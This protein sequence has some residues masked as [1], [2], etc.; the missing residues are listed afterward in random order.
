MS[1]QKYTSELNPLDKKVVKEF[2][3]NEMDAYSTVI[4]DDLLQ[5]KILNYKNKYM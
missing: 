4:V 2:K 3:E 1:Y 5:V